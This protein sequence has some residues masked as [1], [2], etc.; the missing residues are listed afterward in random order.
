MQEGLGRKASTQRGKDERRSTR[1]SPP[2]IRDPPGGDYIAAARAASC[3]LTSMARGVR[4][5]HRSSRISLTRIEGQ[6]I[7]W[8]LSPREGRP[9][10]VRT[11]HL[12]CEKVPVSPSRQAVRAQH[13]PGPRLPHPA[14]L[15]PTPA[16]RRRPHSARC[17]A[18]CAQGGQVL[19]TQR[20]SPAPEAFHLI[21]SRGGDQMR[22][23]GAG[24]G[25]VDRGWALGGRACA[26]F[27]GIAR[28]DRRR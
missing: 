10:V 19:P 27:D 11:G 21:I 12:G 17:G 26:R 22:V 9:L 5:R 7:A 18:I 16:T 25:G 24:R 23:R 6:G 13:T 3:R 2:S 15:P 28:V 1:L 20:A 4:G 14:S 8:G